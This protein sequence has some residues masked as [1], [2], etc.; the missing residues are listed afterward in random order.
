DLNNLKVIAAKCQELG[1]YTLFER[2]YYVYKNICHFDRFIFMLI[3]FVAALT[4]FLNVIGFAIST[5]APVPGLMPIYS[6]SL[7]IDPL[8]PCGVGNAACPALLQDR[9]RFM[10][11]QGASNV[12]I[13]GIPEQLSVN[14]GDDPKGERKV[15]VAVVDNDTA[16][17]YKFVK[18]NKY[19]IPVF[20]LSTICNTGDPPNFPGFKTPYNK[21]NI[22][23]QINLTLAVNMDSW[24]EN[25]WIAEVIDLQQD[26]LNETTIMTINF[27]Q[28][29]SLN[30]NCEDAISI[31]TENFTLCYPNVGKNITCFM[32]THVEKILST[33]AGCKNNCPPVSG[34]G[35]LNTDRVNYSSPKPVYGDYMHK[36]LAI[37]GG[38]IL[39][40][41]CIDNSVGCV[42]S[43]ENNVSQ[44]QERFAE[45]M[46]GITASGVMARR[47]LLSNHG[48]MINIQS[49]VRGTAADIRFTP[50]R[51][52]NLRRSGL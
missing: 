22:T 2:F 40:P 51:R 17:N 34:L 33:P 31:K 43:N 16:I 26:N 30:S 47:S 19:S 48:T 8:T 9:F 46:Y 42:N 49:V 23:D 39:I 7:N 20:S 27:V 44:V 37:Y 11:I 29:L 28:V 3:G 13:N 10:W 4:I 24:L 5:T 41:Q 12:L 21:L 32:N 52:A 45:L 50:P 15:M 1:I 18:D 38:H 35:G 6:K 36:S 25:R 14:W